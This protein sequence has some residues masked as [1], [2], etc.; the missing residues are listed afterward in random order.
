MEQKYIRQTWVFRVKSLEISMVLSLARPEYLKVFTPNTFP[1]S[2]ENWTDPS[3]SVLPLFTKKEL[4]SLIKCQTKAADIL[5]DWSIKLCQRYLTSILGVMSSLSSEQPQK[6]EPDKVPER[7]T[8]VKV[9]KLMKTKRQQV[10]LSSDLYF[11][12]RVVVL[13][14]KR[15]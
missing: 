14:V 11:A 8:A 6:M 7:C 3:L 4:L 15:N 9:A 10:L 2:R 1:A 13:R 12:F 5:V